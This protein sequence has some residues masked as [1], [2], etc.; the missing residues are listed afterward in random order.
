VNGFSI[1]VG[2]GAVLGM[3][4]LARS[5]P[6]RQAGVLMNVGLFVLAMS[7]V[8]ARIFYILENNAYYAA[9]LIESPQIWLGG[10]SWPG[11]LI[12]AWLA[13]LF[14][15]RTQRI[16]GEWG[17]I[18]MAR[19]GDRLYPLLPSLGVSVWLGCWQ[20]GIAYGQ[21]L[22]AGAW[23][24]NPGMDENGIF[25]PRW[26]LQ[27]VAALSLLLFYAILEARIRAKHP[28]GRLSGF[29]ILGL[30]VNILAVSLLRADP[31]PAWNGLRVDA[32]IAIAILATY[33]L[34]LLFNYLFSRIGRRPSYSGL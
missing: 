18:S 16:P 5:A 17:N 19:L 2:F 3:W 24:G 7:L 29:A 4:R 20:A 14:V 31:A 11:A 12:G 8:G 33:C 26:P 32:W 10:L 1:W 34:Y 28:V 27:M 22:P 21:P 9:N 25:T 15:S 6:Q 23:W 13:M 30:L